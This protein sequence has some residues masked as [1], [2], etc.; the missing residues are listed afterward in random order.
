M[1]DEFL[2]ES[3]VRYFEVKGEYY[4]KNCLPSLNNLIH[5]AERNPH[6]YNRLKKQMEYVVINAIRRYLKG[7]KAS[8][9]VRLTY[10]FGEKA[11][12]QKRDY[13]NVSG[14]SSKIIS[15]ALV[16]SGTLHDD[17]PKYVAPSRY[18]FKYTD[19]IPYVRVWIEEVGDTK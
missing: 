16:K 15:D 18:T 19:G 6:A 1:A 13:D 4:G 5:E 14:A 11:K 10:E 2:Q 12:G 17:A 3:E 7:W 9:R 8:K